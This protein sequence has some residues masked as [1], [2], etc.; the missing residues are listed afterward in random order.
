M[1]SNGGKVDENFSFRHNK[2]ALS[3]FCGTEKHSGFAG[4]I[5][6]QEKKMNKIAAMLIVSGLLAGGTVFAQQNRNRGGRGERGGERTRMS[7]EE[8]NK[9]WADVQSQL[10][11]K[12]PE[13]FAEIE[14][15][16]A[17]NIAAA[18]Q[19]MNELAR[20][21]KIAT[22]RG[23]RFGGGREG[24]GGREGGQRGEGFG[25]GRGGFGGQRPGGF[26]GGM[27]GNRQRTEAEAKIKEKFPQEYAAIE[28]QRE[29]AEEQL[30]AL[31]KKA[32]VKLPL[33]QEAMMKKMAA[34]RE[35]Y[36]KEFEEINQLRQ[37][38]PQAARERMA[39]I[40]KQEGIEMPMMMR[41]GEGPR[42]GGDRGEGGPARRGNSRPNIDKIRKAYPEE[43]QKLDEIRRE[44]PAK[45]RE[46][47]RKLAERYERENKK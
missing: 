1:S 13:K 44:D 47:F 7:T 22:P 15:L 6:N 38:D 23:G 20:E 11:K 28:K 41:P 33:T 30:Q 46:E 45:F 8:T 25:G 9:K 42:R 40:F 36:K 3:A 43:M 18:M 35:K 29:T 2:S 14:K 34:I 4:T 37:T 24:F 19:K 10:K 39:E 16:A 17:T 31:A 32:D 12:Y 26:Q 27:M 5:I 21:A